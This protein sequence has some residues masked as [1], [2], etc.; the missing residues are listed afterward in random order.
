MRHEVRRLSEVRAAGLDVVVRPDR[1]VD[2]HLRV[3]IQVTDDERLGA[4]G[5]VEPAFH[6]RGDAGAEIARRLHR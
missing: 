6:R 4:V 5:I 3:A 1:H 2:F